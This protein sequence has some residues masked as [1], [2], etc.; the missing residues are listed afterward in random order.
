MHISLDGV[1]TRRAAIGASA[2]YVE[3]QWRFYGFCETFEQ[4]RYIAVQGLSAGLGAS[5]TPTDLVG[6][7]LI[8]LSHSNFPGSQEA[9]SLQVSRL[10][11]RQPWKR[12]QDETTLTLLWFCSGILDKYPAQKARMQHGGF[13]DTL[14][15]L[16]PKYLMLVSTHALWQHQQCSETCCAMPSCSAGSAVFA[17]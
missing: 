15:D 13:W 3:E 4:A 1:I 17:S 10:H 2:D 6:S 11:T 8:T 14:T 12:P 5:Q 9:H 7:F 16:L